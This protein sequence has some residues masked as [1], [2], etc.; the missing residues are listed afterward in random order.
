MDRRNVSGVLILI[1]S[2][3]FSISIM[4]AESL[5]PDYSISRNY[6]S[7]LGVGANAWL[8]N[9]TV[10]LFG[11]SLI[12]GAI[13][14][15]T[16]NKRSPFPYILALVGIGATMV[17]LFPENTGSLHGIGATIAFISAGLSAITCLNW[18]GTAFRYASIF[19]GILILVSIGLFVNGTYLGLGVGGMERMIVYPGLMWSFGFSSILLSEKS[20]RVSDH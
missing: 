15:A 14:L 17:G 4:I 18:T 5:R 12:I 1:G 8:F 20:E 2:F 10:I 6:I 7:D 3:V 19:I 16:I 13:L 9:C 11:L